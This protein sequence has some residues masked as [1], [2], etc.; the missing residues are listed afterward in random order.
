[1]IE[2]YIFCTVLS[3]LCLYILLLVTAEWWRDDFKRRHGD[4]GIKIFDYVITYRMKA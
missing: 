2:I 1:M 4:D 3:L